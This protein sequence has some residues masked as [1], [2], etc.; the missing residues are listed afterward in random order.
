M[1]QVSNNEE[2]IYKQMTWKIKE[3]LYN[4]GCRGIEVKTTNQAAYGFMQWKQYM[5]LLGF[6]QQDQFPC[7][8]VRLA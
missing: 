6:K 3:K 2:R 8:V 5:E 4:E 1:L 7:R